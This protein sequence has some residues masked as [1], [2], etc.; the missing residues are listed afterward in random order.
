ML[1]L[2][3]HIPFCDNICSYCDFLKTVS[4]IDRKEKYINHIISQIDL[5]DDCYDTIYVGGGTPNSLPDELLKKLLKSLGRFHVKEFT[6]EINPELFSDTQ[7]LYF[8]TYGISRVSIGCQTVNDNLIKIL[9]R[10]HTKQ[11]VID[12]VNSLKKHGI[13]NINLD[14]MFAIINQTLNDVISDLDFYFSLDVTHLSYYSLILEE[15]TLLHHLYLKKEIELVD[16]ELEALMF[17]KVI[18]EA[19]NHGYHHYEISNFSKPGFES[20]HNQIYWLNQNYNAIGL[21]ASGYIDNVRFVNSYSFKDFYCG[22][23]ESE[24]L[25]ENDILKE[26]LMLGLRLIDGVSIK[27][28]ENRFKI[29]V[30]E[31]F[32]DIKRLINQG[33]LEIAGDMLKLTS[34]GIFYG[35]EVF[36]CFV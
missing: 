36:E 17:E 13:F 26:E 9:N 30:L 14:L 31:S 12:C 32:P 29:S 28:I 23:K 3:I 18:S 22:T 24:V 5:L 27:K 35:N 4:N 2:Y 1:G 25:S 15:K 16:N 10:K 6:I 8:K 21:G 7:A 33:L 34:K 11:N 20:I 19:K